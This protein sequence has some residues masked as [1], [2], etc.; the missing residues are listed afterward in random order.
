M[1]ANVESSI[2]ITDERID[3]KALNWS[4]V[5]EI[6]TIPNLNEEYVT[7]TSCLAQKTHALI[8]RFQNCDVAEYFGLGVGNIR[9]PIDYSK[10][11]VYIYIEKDP[12]FPI[13]KVY[14]YSFK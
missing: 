13:Y 10:I 11:C 7:T 4:G 2:L 12:D 3:I 6:V 14:G 1:E 5:S 8:T 9:E